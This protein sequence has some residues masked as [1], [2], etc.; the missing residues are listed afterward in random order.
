MNDFKSKLVKRFSGHYQLL[1]NLDMN[2]K[3][4]NLLEKM[5]AKRI[6]DFQ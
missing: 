5:I 6:H 2:E 1:L 4:R 3:K